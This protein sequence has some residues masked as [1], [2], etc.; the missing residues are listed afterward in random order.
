MSRPDKHDF[1]IFEKAMRA[2]DEALIALG[3]MRDLSG[4]T[5][6]LSIALTHAETGR[7]WLTEDILRRGAPK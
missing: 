3:E 1:R 4:N 5:R 2:Y 6:E 7:L